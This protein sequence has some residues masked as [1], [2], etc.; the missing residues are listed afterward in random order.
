VSDKAKKLSPE[1]KTGDRPRYESPRVLPLGGTG[2]AEG[3][4]TVCG[5]GSGFAGDCMAGAIAT[6]GCIA[7][8]SAG[9]ACNSGG[10]GA[11]VT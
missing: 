9:I 6:I 1:S 8:L 5:V 4:V 7:G 2:A 11:P 10:S 3:G